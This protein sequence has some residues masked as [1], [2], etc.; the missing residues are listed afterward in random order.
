MSPTLQQLSALIGLLVTVGACA[1]P[2]ARSHDGPATIETSVIRELR[3]QLAAVNI[4]GGVSLSPALTISGGGHVVE[5][6]VLLL[7]LRARGRQRKAARVMV[8]AIESHNM[9]ELKRAIAKRALAHRVGDVVHRHVQ[10]AG[11]G[12]T[13]E[14]LDSAR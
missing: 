11:H 7:L 10:R 6:A 4:D 12:T 5:T 1:A 3:S 14:T 13:L 8:G 2:S 9:P